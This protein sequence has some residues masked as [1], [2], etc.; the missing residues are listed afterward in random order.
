MRS[1]QFETIFT[2]AVET[3]EH[4]CEFTEHV[5]LQ[6]LHGKANADTCLNSA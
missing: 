6:R 2:G 4:L 1:T 3:A 5:G